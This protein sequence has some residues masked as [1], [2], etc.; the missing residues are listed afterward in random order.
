MEI[1]SI[2]PVENVA[3]FYRMLQ[4]GMISATGL[5]LENIVLYTVVDILSGGLVGGK[6]IGAEIS[7]I[8]MFFLNNHFTFAERPGATLKRFLKSNLVRSGGV[9]IGL[10]V[11]EIGT[12]LGIWYIFA[13]LIGIAVGF[14]FN[15][16][17]ESVYTWAEK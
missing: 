4:Y 7:I 12:G 10:V 3:T 2:L 11:L 14:L 17:M 15:F 16:T 1:D 6:L 9:L 5:L 13:N 8:A